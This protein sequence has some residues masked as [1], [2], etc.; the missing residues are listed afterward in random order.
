MS[1]EGEMPLYVNAMILVKAYLDR[2][3]VDIWDTALWDAVH[4]NEDGSMTDDT[5][6]GD[7]K[8]LNQAFLYGKRLYVENRKHFEIWH[9]GFIAGLGWGIDTLASRVV[10]KW[11][12][13]EYQRQLEE[14][15][16]A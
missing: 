10:M 2:D 15:A 8:E 6:N 9:R 5:F 14:E 11:E 16:H 1:K 12:E 7:A 3:D 13:E 4:F